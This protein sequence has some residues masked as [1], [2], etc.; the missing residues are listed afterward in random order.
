M[1]DVRGDVLRNCGGPSQKI[2]LSFLQLSVHLQPNESAVF[3][4][5]P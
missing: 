3:V 2:N 1:V 5:N 4:I